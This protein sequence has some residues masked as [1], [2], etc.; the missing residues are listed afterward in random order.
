MSLVSFGSLLLQLPLDELRLLPEELRELRFRLLP[1]ELR[2]LRLLLDPLELRELRRRITTSSTEGL[3]KR[4]ELLT[5]S[6]AVL[7]DWELVPMNIVA[8]K[9]R[10]PTLR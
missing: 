5:E 6:C 2:E 4:T 10:T 8:V 9:S 7:T 1:D 3:V